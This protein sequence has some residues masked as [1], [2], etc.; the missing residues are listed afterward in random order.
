MHALFTHTHLLNSSITQPDTSIQVSV[1]ESR[2]EWPETISIMTK[3]TLCLPGTSSYEN[4]LMPEVTDYPL[5]FPFHFLFLYHGILLRPKHVPPG[6]LIWCTS[7]AAL[8]L[9]IFPVVNTSFVW[10]KE[11]FIFLSYLRCKIPYLSSG[12]ILYHSS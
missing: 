7:D 6:L 10:V 4:T 8:L 9:P 1:C 12:I 11:T 5:F 3:H 2:S